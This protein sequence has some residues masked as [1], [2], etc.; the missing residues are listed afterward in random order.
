MSLIEDVQGE[1]VTTEETT[2]E[3]VEEGVEVKT[4]EQP[5]AKERPENIPEDFWNAETGSVDTEKLLESYTK[6][7][8]IAKDLRAQIGKGHQNPPE[9]VDGYVLELNEDLQQF[10]PDDDPLVA[11]A[12]EAAYEMGMSVGQFNNFVSPMI[13]KMAE[14]G[15]FEQEQAPEIDQAAEIEKI[16]GK[17]ALVELKTYLDRA[18]ANNTLDAEIAPRVANW[19]QTAEDVAAFKALRKDFSASLGAIPARADSLAGVDKLEA[20]KQAQA[21]A[22]A[23]GSYMNDPE[24]QKR[25]SQMYSEAVGS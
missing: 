8:K 25:I 9:E 21:K 7:D 15:M 12:K 5:L 2:Q 18:V 11:V 4:E 14:K 1:E 3:V 6:A 24:V 22:I 13:A 20:A 10:V 17:E 16:G 23:D 19:L